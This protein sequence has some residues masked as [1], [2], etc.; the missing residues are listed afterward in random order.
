MRKR[1]FI[2]QICIKGPNVFRGYLHNEEKTAEAL[3]SDGWLHTGDVGQW[4]PVSRND[5]TPTWKLVTKLC[6]RPYSVAG[7]TGVRV[8]FGLGKELV[9]ISAGITAFAI[10]PSQGWAGFLPTFL[11]ILFKSPTS[12]PEPFPSPSPNPK[13][14]GNEV[15]RSHPPKCCFI[16]QNGAL[17]II[18]RKKDIFKLSQV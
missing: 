3:D 13:A 10:T 17:K 4:L 14:T 12:S 7:E 18:D 5:V 1:V 9:W 16:F 2:S 11:H 8:G 15:A 6:S